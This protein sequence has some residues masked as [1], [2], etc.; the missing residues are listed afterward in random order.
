M[1]H[2]RRSERKISPKSFEM[3]LLNFLQSTGF[4]GVVQ[5]AHEA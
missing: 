3:R 2:A 1:M 4:D 5:L